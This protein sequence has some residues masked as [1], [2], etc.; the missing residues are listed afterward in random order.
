MKKALALLMTALLVLSVFSGCGAQAESSA[1][2]SVP[3]EAVSVPTAEEPAQAP[4]EP[5]AAEEP[6]SAAETISVAEPESEPIVIEYPVS[7]NSVSFEIFTMTP[8]RVDSIAQI[9]SFEEASNRTGV[10]IEWREVAFLAWTESLNLMM[11]SGD[12]ADMAVGSTMQ[13]AT[14]SLTADQ[15]IEQNILV[16]LTDYLEENAPDYYKLLQEDASMLREI[17]TPEGAI[18]AFWQVY[19]DVVGIRGDLIRQD[20]LDEQGLAV[21]ET[22][23][24]LYEVLKV[25]KSA[26]DCDHPYLMNKTG[27]SY[28]QLNAGYDIAG[29][30]CGESN[31]GMFVKEDIIRCTLLEDGFKEYIEMLAKWY[32]EG[33]IGKDFT[34]IE[35]SFMDG[36]RKELFLTD[37]AGVMYVSNNGSV[38]YPE[39]AQDPDFAM[40]PLKHITK[41]KGGIVHFTEDYSR[42]NN[43]VVI[44]TACEDVELACK[45][46]NYFYTEEGSLLATYG[47]EGVDWDYNDAGKPEFTDKVMKHESLTPSMAM[48]TVT[49]S[50]GWIGLYPTDIKTYFYGEQQFTNAEVWMSNCDSEYVLIGVTSPLAEDADDYNSKLSDITT[51]ADT[52]VLSFIIGEQ[53]LSEWDSFIDTIK[54]MGIEDCVAALQRAYDHSLEV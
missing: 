26:Y 23:D 52:M 50:S 53:P 41:E 32:G 30:R 16:D 9:V 37:E 54:S 36:T 25:F 31:V 45:F 34:S 22:Y 48:Q 13:S 20:W 33:L 14:G 1:V 47:I 39:Q 10:G 5:P 27:S 44:F 12:Y 3:Q 11:A 43:N 51:Y 21:P 28:Y 17:R 8:A 4:E 2:E 24:E 38:E 35:S 42:L 7:D 29:Y 40:S 46:L 15:A 49:M 6:V 18:S 19:E